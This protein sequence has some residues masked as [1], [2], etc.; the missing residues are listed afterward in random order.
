MGA[1]DGSATFKFSQALHVPE[2]RKLR[3]HHLKDKGDFLE[4]LV[5]N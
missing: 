5:I 1:Q 3:L 2:S 4:G